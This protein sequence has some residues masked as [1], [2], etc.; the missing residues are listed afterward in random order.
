M[1]AGW[2]EMLAVQQDRQLEPAE[3]ARLHDEYGERLRLFLLGVL[4]DPDAA[5]EVLQ[6]VFV[7]AVE[8]CHA[9]RQATAV[10]WLYRV[11]FHEAMRLR[12]RE[13]I[14][15]RVFEQL[16]RQARTS[17]PTEP[18]APLVRAE[19]TEAVRRALDR[20]PPEQR[21][22]VRMRIYEDKTFATIAAELNEPLGTVLSRMRL[23]LE[24]LR[25]E[26]QET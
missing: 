25:R 21:I 4:R 17:D 10:G 3:V 14:G 1:A 19:T 18:A 12:R 2:G 7:K 24:K 15:Q 6:A 22:V 26:F 9:V 11:A 20:L 16:S 13:S 23:A 8:Q 5:A